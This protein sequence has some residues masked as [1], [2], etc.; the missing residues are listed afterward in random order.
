MFRW[1]GSP[2]DAGSRD[3]VQ[4]VFHHIEQYSNI[5]KSACV[6]NHQRHHFHCF[7]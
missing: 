1:N 7:F 5:S 2:D 3:T 6:I 4:L